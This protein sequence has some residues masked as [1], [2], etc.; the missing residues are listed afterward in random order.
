MNQSYKSAKAS[1][2]SDEHGDFSVDTPLRMDAFVLDD[3][4]KIELIEKNFREIMYVLG[5]DLKDDSLKDTPS[6]VAKMYVQEIF[7]GLNPANKPEIS[8]FDNK[9]GFRHMLVEKGIRVQ[10][11]CEH[12]F[13]PIL[14]QAAIG[15]I[16][17]KKIIGLSKLNRI[18]EYYSRRPQVQERLTLQIA[19]ELRNALETDDVAVVINAS[20]LCVTMR[21]I[22]DPESLTTSS[23]FSGKF[24]DPAMRSE[25]LKYIE[26]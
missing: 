17:D 8:L 9:Y 1:A 25:F 5:L 2:Q 11:H 6:R 3:A 18:V 12:H 10:S 13:V 15:Y 22:R 23:H 19:E 21:G 14:G 26:A 4:T 20:H 24:L 7:S 16:P